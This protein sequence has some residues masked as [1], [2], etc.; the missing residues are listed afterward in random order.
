MTF[1]YGSDDFKNQVQTRFETIVMLDPIQTV[2]KTN[3]FGQITDFDYLTTLHIASKSGIYEDY[4]DKY[5][6]RLS[7]L[8]DQLVNILNMLSCHCGIK[9]ITINTTEFINKFDVNVDGVSATIKFRI[10]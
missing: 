10:Y 6:E 7:Q 2:Y 4:G 3:D 1:V 9:F 5:F 8:K